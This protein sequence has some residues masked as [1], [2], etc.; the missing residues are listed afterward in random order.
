MPP[1]FDTGQ[2]QLSSKPPP[3]APAAPSKT[4]L[5]C[6]TDGSKTDTGACG[7]ATVLLIGCPGDGKIITTSFFLP[8]VHDNNAAEL[9]AIIN[10]IDQA[11]ALKASDFPD[12]ASITI[13]SDSMNSVNSIQGIFLYTDPG[14]LTLLHRLSRTLSTLKINMKID[15]DLYCR[16]TL[17]NSKKGKGLLQLYDLI[18]DALANGEISSVPVFP[19]LTA[20]A[21]DKLST[22]KTHQAPFQTAALIFI[23]TPIEI[24]RRRY[25][26]FVNPASI[27]YPD[28]VN[29]PDNLR[30]FPPRTET[31]HQV[32]DMLSASPDDCI[33]SARVWA[34]RQMQTGR[35]DSPSFF[36]DLPP[37]IDGS[38]TT[39]TGSL[40]SA[41]DDDISSSSSSD[42]D[43]EDN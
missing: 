34:R 30:P 42:I 11:I 29:F 25:S 31:Y 12:L 4:H 41:F 26:F 15:Q 20:A 36:P 35:I 17:V 22:A 40:S 38:E 39:F 23:F 8:H 18:R 10:V 33:H 3:Y 24:L 6:F 14:F 13:I 7:C 19:A 1:A 37:E 27:S 9:Q 43:S 32:S 5:L 16:Q 21:T 28:R 2:V